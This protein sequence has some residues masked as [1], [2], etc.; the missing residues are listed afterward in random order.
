MAEGF[1]ALAAILGGGR[2]SAARPPGSAQSPAVTDSRERATDEREA[3][4]DEPARGG[5]PPGPSGWA[6]AP[7]VEELARM[8]LAAREAF[9][10]GTVRLLAALADDVLARE[11]RLADCDLAALAARVLAAAGAAEPVVLVV[12]ESA[13]VQLAEVGLPVRR[14]A[15]LGPGDLIVEVRD[16]SLESP[17]AF[18]LAGALAASAVFA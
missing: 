9:E 2:A 17:F 8:R 12:G 4:S 16:G 6:A 3:P 15:A 1:V 14:D 10:R 7:V 18:R 5:G 11:L 13:A